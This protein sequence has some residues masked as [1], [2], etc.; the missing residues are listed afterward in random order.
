[1]QSPTVLRVTN[2][3]LTVQVLDVVEAK[4][5]GNPEV[6]VAVKVIGEVLIFALSCE[7][8]I[9]CTVEPVIIKDCVTGVASCHV[10]LPSC[11]AEITHEPPETKVTVAV[12][13]LTESVP[14]PTVQIP[15]VVE[16]N[17]ISKLEV[18]LALIDVL[19]VERLASV[20]LT[21]VIVCVCPIVKVTCT[22]VAGA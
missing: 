6:E 14:V 11:E 15:A 13:V 19:L 9:V 22:S 21:K 8:V 1:M 16:V 2:I 7:K 18:V 4:V 12:V 5:T 10:P 3:S 17:V 20:G